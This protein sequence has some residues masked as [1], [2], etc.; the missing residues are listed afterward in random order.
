MQFVKRTKKLT[1]Q[2]IRYCF[3]YS[4]ATAI[5]AAAASFI[6]PHCIWCSCMLLAIVLLCICSVGS[7]FH[8]LL[9]YLSFLFVLFSTLV[10][11]SSTVTSQSF[12]FSSFYRQCHNTHEIISHIFRCL[13]FFCIFDV[14]VVVVVVLVLGPHCLAV[15]VLLLCVGKFAR[16]FH[17]PKILRT[18]SKNKRD[19]HTVLRK[20]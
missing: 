18:K 16:I 6:W 1:A 14:V 3:F 10:K 12:T 5:A 8:K 4:A 13:S 19:S 17:L 11:A 9:F 20:S 7:Y 2:S 15:L